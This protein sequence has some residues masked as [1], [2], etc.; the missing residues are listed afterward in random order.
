MFTQRP[1]FPYWRLLSIRMLYEQAKLG[2]NG[3]LAGYLLK[4][5]RRAH[6]NQGI[7]T[8]EPA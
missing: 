5:K 2:E 8:I 4:I 1:I 6:S 7:F 3:V